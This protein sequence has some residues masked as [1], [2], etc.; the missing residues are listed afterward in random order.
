MSVPFNGLQ[1]VMHHDG[2]FLEDL[3]KLLSHAH[4][5]VVGII[6][7]TLHLELDDCRRTETRN[8][9]VEHG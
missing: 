8:K 7:C 4:W 5:H 6:A 3:H 9:V 1:C 2:L